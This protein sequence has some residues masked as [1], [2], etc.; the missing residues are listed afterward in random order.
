MWYECDILIICHASC[1]NNNNHI[2]FIMLLYIH[3]HLLIKTSLRTYRIELLAAD[4][5]DACKQQPTLS[6]IVILC[7]LIFTPFA[8]DK[9]KFAGMISWWW[10]PPLNHTGLKRRTTTTGHLLW[11]ASVPYPIGPLYLNRTTAFPLDSSPFFTNTILMKWF[12]L[13]ILNEY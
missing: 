10:S 6:E 7:D 4:D 8:I 2:L 9:G 1:N 11:Y 5:D 3:I 12:F 13:N